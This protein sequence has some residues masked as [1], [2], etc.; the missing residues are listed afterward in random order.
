[1]LT[2]IAALDRNRAIGRGNAMPWHLPDDLRRFK[3]LSMGRPVLMG[4]RTA[5][6]IGRPLPGRLNLVLSR[7][8]SAPF[9][10]QHTVR[11]LDEARAT[12]GDDLV[13]AGGA[14]IY[15]LCLPYTQIMFLTWV[16][17][18]LAGA[19]AHFPQFDPGRWEITGREPHPADGRHAYPFEWVDYRRTDGS[20]GAPGPAVIR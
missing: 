18:T 12:A 15:A 1:M 3:A 5:E 7:A 14:E 8:G 11:S 13:V 19:D 2:I 4:R 16:D 6:S 17:T 10:G 20:G 9:E